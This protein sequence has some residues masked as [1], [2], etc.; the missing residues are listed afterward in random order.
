MATIL[1]KQH[2]LKITFTDTPTI[3]GVVVP[4]SNLIGCTLTFLIKSL[5]GAVAVKKSATILGDGTFSYNPV[6]SDVAVAGDFLQEW[7]VVFPGA[8]PLTFPNGS[9][10]T[11]KILPDLG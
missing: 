11:L 7:E 10:N 2:D 8:L 1:T 4:P 5:D 6:A 3:N 9:Y